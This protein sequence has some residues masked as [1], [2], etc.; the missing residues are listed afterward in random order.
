MRA[1]KKWVHYQLFVC[2]CS[3]S[4]ESVFFSYTYPVNLIFS[5]WS[6]SSTR[7]HPDTHLE[8][9]QHMRWPGQIAGGIPASI[10]DCVPREKFGRTASS[11][12]R[13]T[14][15][16]QKKEKKA[17]EIDGQTPTSQIFPEKEFFWRWV[18]VNLLYEMIK[19]QT[20]IDRRRRNVMRLR[21]H[22]DYFIP[23]IKD[24]GRKLFQQYMRPFQITEKKKR[25]PSVPSSNSQSLKNPSRFYLLL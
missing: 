20:I 2:L 17:R 3:F 19:G 12:R 15:R 14:R 1:K 23:L 13:G 5:K 9:A 18:L 4:F 25:N 6:F 24:L 8:H 21:F 11:F 7:F 10:R 16:P 22:H